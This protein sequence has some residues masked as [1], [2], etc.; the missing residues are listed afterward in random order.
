MVTP[1]MRLTVGHW[2]DRIPGVLNSVNLSWQ[3]DYPWEVS[4]DEDV[5]ILPHVLDVS[6]GF[7]P[8]H[9]FLPEKGISSPFILPH[10]TTQLKE[11]QKWYK[12]G[13]E[14]DSLVAGGGRPFSDR[15]ND[16]KSPDEE[17]I[18]LNE[19]NGP[20]SSFL[21]NDDSSFE[22]SFTLPAQPIGTPA[23]DVGEVEFLNEGSGGTLIP[24][25]D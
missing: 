12:L 19:Y 3:K 13:I 25:I 2:C 6:V 4:R 5:L 21:P 17:S 16:L 24:D 7:T 10:S 22:G 9:N 23:G 8:V 15:L 14:E 20:E 1:F 11:T 18:D